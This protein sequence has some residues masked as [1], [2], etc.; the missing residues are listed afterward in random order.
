MD[1]PQKVSMIARLGLDKRP[2]PRQKAWD[3]GDVDGIGEFQKAMNGHNLYPLE[4]I[5]DGRWQRFAVDKGGNH[6]QDGFY[7]LNQGDDGHFWGCYG[8]WSN[9]GE[10]IPFSSRKVEGPYLY[11][12]GTFFL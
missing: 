10:P 6:N 8:D 12:M 11:L 9:G 4:I 1:N 7:I 5:A 3:E 2:P